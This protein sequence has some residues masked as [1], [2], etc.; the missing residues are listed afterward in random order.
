M[1]YDLER[2]M[3][4]QEYVYDGVLG[5]LRSGRKS[6]HWIWF[7]FPQVAGL[8]HSDISRYFA[9]GSLDEARA[10][11]A[12][13]V[14][15]ARLRECARIVLETEGGTAEDIF[16][17]TDAMKVRSCMTLFHRVAPHD[18]VFAQ[19]LDRYYGGVADEATD[20]RLR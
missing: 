4:A 12:H 7:I 11:L 13:P 6:G 17:P 9:I 15:G 8:G 14:L 2:F 3:A 18:P 10:Y 5:E 16:G 19:V 1:P 20:A